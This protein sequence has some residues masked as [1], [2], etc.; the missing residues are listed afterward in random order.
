MSEAQWVVRSERHRF[1]LGKLRRSH[2]TTWLY[3]AA[4]LAS[5]CQDGKEV[6][7]LIGCL[8]SLSKETLRSSLSV[9]GVDAK[10]VDQWSA[11]YKALNSSTREERRGRSEGNSNTASTSRWTTFW[12]VMVVTNFSKPFWRNLQSMCIHLQCTTSNQGRG[13]RF[14]KLSRRVQAWNRRRQHVRSQIAR[15]TIQSWGEMTKQF[16]KKKVMSTNFVLAGS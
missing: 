9:V 16:A 6:L 8:A 13:A 14:A 10:V 1:H 15:G 2:S 12:F 11:K 7:Q 3:H 4:T 5:V